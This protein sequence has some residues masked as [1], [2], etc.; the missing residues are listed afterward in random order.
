MS[1]R[2]INLIFVNTYLSD[3]IRI[4][5]RKVF[6]LA[7]HLTCKVQVSQ[8][9]LRIGINSYGL[10]KMPQCLSIKI[11]DDLPLFTVAKSLSYG[12]A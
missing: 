3:K 12:L 6:Y 10:I 9:G 5:F 2:E 1:I 8:I 7:H 11:D 4:G